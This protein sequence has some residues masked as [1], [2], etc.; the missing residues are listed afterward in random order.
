[1]VKET[2]F[3]GELERKA[4]NLLGKRFHCQ[5]VSVLNVVIFL[6]QMFSIQV[7]DPCCHSVNSSP[8]FNGVTFENVC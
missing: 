4:F 3:T 7:Q 2:L 6:P 8:C 1:M 5:T